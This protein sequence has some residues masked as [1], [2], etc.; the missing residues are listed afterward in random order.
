MSNPIYNAVI[1]SASIRI[2]RGFMLDS[3]LHVRY[4]KGNQGFGGFV[5][6]HTKKTA[7]GG[8]FAGLWLTRCMEIAGV[9]DWGR[10]KGRTIRIRK[11]GTGWNSGIEA[12]GH[13]VE[14]KWFNPGLEFE[15]LR[16]QS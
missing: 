10:M 14:D 8:N 1:E 2:E 5:L 6:A 15:V 12:I 7:E 13:I 11:D 9:D 3:W 16:G 4:E